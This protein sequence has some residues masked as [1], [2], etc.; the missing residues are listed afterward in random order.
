MIWMTGAWT[1]IRGKALLL[2]S[3]ALGLSLLALA[4]M[5]NRLEERD[6]KLRQAASWVDTSKRI[7]KTDQTSDADEATQWL[8]E[9]R[10]ESSES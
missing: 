3:G 10:N 1:W 9:R 7:M 2:L 8:E 6:M 4:Y 5:R